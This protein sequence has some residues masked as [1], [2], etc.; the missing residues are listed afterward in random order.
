MFYCYWLFVINIFVFVAFL[1]IKLFKLFKIALIE[2]IERSERIVG[3]RFYDDY[4]VLYKT[5]YF[6]YKK[7]SWLGWKFEVDICL[8]C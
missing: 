7:V 1:F 6:E 8:L 4:A 3:E 5:A 2:I